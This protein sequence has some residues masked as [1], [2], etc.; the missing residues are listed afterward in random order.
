MMPK[1]RA[2]TPEVVTFLEEVTY[3]QG[4][5]QWAGVISERRGRRLFQTLGLAFA[6]A[7]Q[8]IQ[9]PRR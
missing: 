7:Q 9:R 5:S 1:E 6:K 3:E 8:D 2:G 4:L